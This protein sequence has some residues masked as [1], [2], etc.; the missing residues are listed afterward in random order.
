MS[1]ILITDKSEAFQILRTS[2][3]KRPATSASYV[4]RVNRAIDHI[5]SHLSEPLPLNELARAARLSPFH[6]HRVF[7]ALVGA[8]PAD[9]VKRLRLEKA[10]GLMARPRP[11]ALTSIALMSGFSSSSD[12]TR[13]F[14]QRFGVPPSAFNVNTWQAAHEGELEFLV[15]NSVRIDRL[16]PRSNPDKFQVK[17]RELPSRTVAYIRID[18]PYR[19]DGVFRA[20]RRL[21]EWAEKQGFAD[22][23][24]LGYQWDDPSITS[25]DDCRYYIAVEADEFTA[26]GEIGKYKFPSMMVA[27][28]EIR[29]GIELE[30]RALK[31]IYGTWLPR[32]GYVPD[33]FPGF[34]AFIG[35]PFAHGGNYFELHGQVPIRR[36]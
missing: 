5:V 19:G 24:W 17:I 7:Q 21:M 9:F 28:L 8:T 32:S 36:A 10:L 22:R 25:L 29:G 14:K 34:E 13:S 33:N 15:A 6:F 3:K 30:L 35:R 18:R 2:L 23:Q 26:K 31:W 11:P 12:F 16:P 27:Q 4:E 20:A 1:C